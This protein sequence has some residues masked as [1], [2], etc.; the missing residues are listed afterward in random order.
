MDAPC[1]H[2]SR[3]VRI[4]RG[5]SRR[6]LPGSL[7]RDVRTFRV[8]SR[9]IVPSAERCCRNVGRDDS[10]D[11]VRKID[12]SAV[13]VRGRGKRSE[14]QVTEWDAL[15][16]PPLYSATAVDAAHASAVFCGDLPQSGCAHVSVSARTVRPSGVIGEFR[17]ENDPPASVGDHV[18]GDLERGIAAVTVR[19]DGIG[20]RRAAGCCREDGRT[21]RV[22]RFRRA[23]G[24]GR[25]PVRSLAIPI[26]R[27]V[28][29]DH[30]RPA[31]RSGGTKAGRGIG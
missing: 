21:T 7:V 3:V 25:A 5:I 29:T 15:G 23:A 19:V 13:G 6:T 22:I 9:I 24:C 2:R 18:A 31:C 17:I 10:D 27:S 12:R 28:G 14:F 26:V 1:A 8:P 30:I 20:S 16:V 4:V 11:D